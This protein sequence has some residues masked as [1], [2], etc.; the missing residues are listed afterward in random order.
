MSKKIKASDQTI[1]QVTGGG[2]T[3]APKQSGG[4]HNQRGTTTPKNTFNNGRGP[5]GK[6][7]GDSFG[8]PGK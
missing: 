1:N 3:R 8:R 7:P 4:R 6:K 2:A 5:A